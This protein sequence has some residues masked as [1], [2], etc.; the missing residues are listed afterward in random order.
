MTTPLGDAGHILH[1]DRKPQWSTISV[2]ASSATL[3]DSLS[4]AMV[5]ANRDEIEAIRKE[6]DVS[7]VTLVDWDGDLTTL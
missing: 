6:A 5:L 2:E 7:R 3:A 1:P 4:T